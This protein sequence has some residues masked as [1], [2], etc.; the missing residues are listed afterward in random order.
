[1]E[2]QRMLNPNPEMVGTLLEASVSKIAIDPDWC[3]SDLD[4]DYCCP[5]CKMVVWEP[6]L[7]L[8]AENEEDRCDCQ[9]LYCNGCLAACQEERET[10]PLCKRAW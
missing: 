6:R 1:M 8:P 10:C 4:K 7:N 2:E 5:I 9:K 3:P